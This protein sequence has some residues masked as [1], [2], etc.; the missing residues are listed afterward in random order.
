MKYIFYDI[1]CANCYQGKGKICSFGYVIT[2][3]NF[4]I[5]EQHDMVMNPAS[6]FNLGPDIKLAYSKSEF[7]QAPLFPMFYDE[8]E[9][10]LTDPD[11]LI[12]GFSV[13]NDARYVRDE[14]KRY[15]LPH[16]NYRFYDVQQMFMGYE[17]VK[18]QPSLAKICEQYGIDES[19]E[20]HKSDDDSRMTM[21]VLQALCKVTG[22]SV[23]ELIEEY[24]RSVGEAVDGEVK[25]LF[26]PPKEEKPQPQPSRRA[27]SNTMS[28]YTNNYK[29]F[30]QY[31]KR[32]PIVEDEGLP[33]SGKKVCISANYE[34]KHY[35]QMK[36]IARMIADLGGR[37]CMYASECDL[38]VSYDYVKA[39]G[40]I[41]NC[42]RL[43][44]VREAIEKKGK[45][46]E[47]LPFA[48]FLEL[49]GTTEA[50]LDEIA[51]PPEPTETPAEDAVAEENDE[52]PVVNA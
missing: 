47:I 18:N 28:R 1:E 30:V 4:E 11:C 9:A 52:L 34:E 45:A 44:R 15:E 3:E 38:F 7:K 36:E 29:R 19:Q 48:E 40:T 20:I 25:W 17:G 12:F 27:K 5:T 50:E 41:K 43:A 37:Y 6:K 31:I 23:P 22:K 42:S 13:N 33:L 2:D 21:E 32:L 16:I 39:D 14:C 24:P 51:I 8:I 26:L 10:L 35:L 49:I 46:I